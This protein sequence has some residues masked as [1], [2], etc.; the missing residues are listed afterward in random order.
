MVELKETNNTNTLKFNDTTDLNFKQR[1]ADLIGNVYLTFD[2]P[3]IYSGETVN[4]NTNTQITPLN[5]NGL[6]TLERA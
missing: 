5:S 2:I 6:K 1:D 3:D 4:T